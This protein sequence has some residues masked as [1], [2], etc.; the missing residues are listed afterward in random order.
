MYIKRKPCRLTEAGIFYVD[1]KDDKLLQRY[2]TEEG[3]VIPRR[4]SGASAWHQ[5]Q[6]VVAIK[7]ARHMAMLP[8]VADNPR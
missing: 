5:R 3:K 8:F 1:Y 7:R 2:I 6:L 4:I